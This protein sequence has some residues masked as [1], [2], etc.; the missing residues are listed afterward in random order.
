MSY[1]IK[2]LEV[3]EKKVRKL[4]RKY[5]S[6]K[7]ELTSLVSNLKEKPDLGV[8]IGNSCF[9]IRLSIASKG[10]GKSGGARVITYV[11][12]IRNTVYLLTIFDKSEQESISGNDLKELLKLIPGE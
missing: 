5:P 3:F 6:L 1:E 2:T 7:D 11:K 9:K 4:I 12:F 8:S 10:K